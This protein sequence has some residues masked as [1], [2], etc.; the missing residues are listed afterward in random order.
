M[1][2]G[3]TF[4]VLEALGRLPGRRLRTALVSLLGLSIDPSATLTRWREMRR[5]GQISIGAGSIIGLWATLDGRGGGIRI[6]ENVNVSSETAFWTM[7]H[8]PQATDFG[9]TRGRIVIEDR[10]WIS[11]RAVIL[12]GV[13][14]GE[15]AVVAAGAVVTKDV[16]PFT[17]VGGIPA[18]KIGERRRDLDYDWRQGLDSPWFI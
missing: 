5:P 10:A 14:V 4:L 17:I 2:R 9:I 16:A 18:K 13:T 15:G 11:F 3:L 8:D 6:G 1:R 12:P 7:Q